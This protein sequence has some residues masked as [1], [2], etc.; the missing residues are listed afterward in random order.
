LHLTI[1]KK[2]DPR[3]AKTFDA[4]K[5]IDQ[6]LAAEKENDAVQ[7]QKETKEEI[8][9]GPVEPGPVKPEPV[10]REPVEP[11]TVE[12]EPVAP[13]KS[14]PTQFDKPPKGIVAAL[15]MIL[16]WLKSLGIT[17]K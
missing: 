5:F 2:S 13:K 12:L 7:R 9:P 4:E 6:K 10:E 1:A 11:D 14:E 8:K 16:Q 3:Y 17:G 15:R